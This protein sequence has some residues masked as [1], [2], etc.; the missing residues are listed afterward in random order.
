MRIGSDR[1]RCDGFASCMIVAPD[2]FDLDGDDKVQVLDPTPFD[3]RH[4]EI[5]DAVLACPT[6][7]IWIER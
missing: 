4:A 6:Q 7:A 1:A 2:V 3:A 5:T